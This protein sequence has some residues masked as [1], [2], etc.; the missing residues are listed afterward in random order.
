MRRI[1]T[2]S[3]RFSSLEERS[4]N[5]LA[6]FDQR[7]ARLLRLELP[8]DQQA[9]VVGQRIENHRDIGRVLQLQVALQLDEVLSMLHLLEQVVARGLLAAG[10]RRQHAMTVEQAHDLVAQV[11]TGLTRGFG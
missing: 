8:K 9:I 11:A 4:P 5:R 2:S 10:E 6:R 7:G 1:V 3:S